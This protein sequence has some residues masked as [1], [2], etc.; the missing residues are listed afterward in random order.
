[1]TAGSRREYPV[2]PQV[3]TCRAFPRHARHQ[4]G[5]RGEGGARVGAHPSSPDT[6][7]G[8]GVAEVLWSDSVMRAM[9][10]A[11]SRSSPNPLQSSCDLLLPGLLWLRS[12]FFNQS[13]FFGRHHDQTLN[14]TPPEPPNLRTPRAKCGNSQCRGNSLWMWHHRTLKLQAGWCGIIV[15]M[16]KKGKIEGKLG[17]STGTEPGRI[18]GPWTRVHPLF[19]HLLCT[20]IFLWGVWEGPKTGAHHLVLDIYPRYSLLVTRLTQSDPWQKWKKWPVVASCLVILLLSPCHSCKITQ[21]C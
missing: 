9:V 6:R 7:S 20:Q 17:T 12:I 3:D 13:S 16:G 2:R 8:H 15:E 10:W 14:I 5:Y 1:V 21:N 19:Y 4:Y 18:E 11:R